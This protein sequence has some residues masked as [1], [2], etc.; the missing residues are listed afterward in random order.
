[1]IVRIKDF[2]MIKNIAAMLIKGKLGI[3]PSKN[4][5]MIIALGK[6][7]S[8][9]KIRI[10]KEKKIVRPLVKVIL[11]EGFDKEVKNYYSRIPA[12]KKNF[13]ESFKYSDIIFVSIKKKVG[14]FTFAINPYERL[15]LNVLKKPIYASSANISGEKTPFSIQNISTKIRRNVDFIFDAGNLPQRRDFAVIN[16]DD[17]TWIR[18]GACTPLVEKY[19][20][21]KL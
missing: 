14:G 6:Q 21:D 8:P 20:R 5:Y 12:E 19:S 9:Q 16:L 3:F 2:S 11:H 4:G 15:L 1:M 10:L 17:M 13:I 7:E 18:K